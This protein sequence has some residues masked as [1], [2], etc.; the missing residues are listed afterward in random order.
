MCVKQQHVLLGLWGGPQADQNPSNSAKRAVV[1][2]A[3]QV[4]GGACRLWHSARQALLPEP[5]QR[6]D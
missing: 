1:C 6:S 4:R 3:V 2:C 5:V